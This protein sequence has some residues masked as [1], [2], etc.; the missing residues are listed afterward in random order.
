MV[1]GPNHELVEEL[2]PTGSR[3]RVETLYDS[4]KYTCTVTGEAG[5]VSGTA[6]IHVLN[7]QY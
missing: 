5:Q 6:A 1:G 7:G 3:L 4:A 2:L